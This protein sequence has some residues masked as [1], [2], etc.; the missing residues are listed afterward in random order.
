MPP[1]QATPSPFM[2]VKA[3]VRVRKLDSR[4]VSAGKDESVALPVA[5]Q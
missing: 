5:L 1:D 2:Y 3:A 4:H